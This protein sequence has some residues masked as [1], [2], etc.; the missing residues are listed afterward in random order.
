MWSREAISPSG[1]S[2]GGL[3]RP[4][5]GVPSS[6]Q[7]FFKFRNAHFLSWFHEGV[8]NA[9]AEYMQVS[10]EPSTGSGRQLP[11]RWV[12]IMILSFWSQ[13]QDGIRPPRCVDDDG[14]EHRRHYF[15]ETVNNPGPGLW[16]LSCR[17]DRKGVITSELWSA[18][19]NT[20]LLRILSAKWN[21]VLP[22]FEW[23]KLC[24]EPI[25]YDETSEN[26][27]VCDEEEDQEMTN[28]EMWREMLWDDF[29][30]NSSSDQS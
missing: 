7:P 18:K 10:R 6:Q 16:S 4:Q 15:G 14:E 23:T 3:N 25:D 24:K 26:A 20:L 1:P 5:E 19:C 12:K 21:T 8:F 2:V 29:T 28:S 13:P 27:I 17:N 22:N 30:L 11:K 9:S